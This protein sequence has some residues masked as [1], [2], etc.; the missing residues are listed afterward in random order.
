MENV[1]CP[2]C[3]APIKPTATFCLTCDTPV[4]DTERGLSVAAPVTVSV[5][6]PLVGLGIAT[7]CLVVLGALAWGTIA[8]FQHRHA[9]AM[10][11]ATGSVERGVA[12]LV[13]AEGGR[14]RACGGAERVLAGSPATTAHECHQIVDHDPG[15]RLDQLHVARP[16]L[17]ADSGTVSISATVS[18]GSG[19]HTIARVVDLVDQ[20]KHWHMSWDGRPVL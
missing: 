12:L 9:A 19:T 4:T 18:D 2:H 6:R 13:S 10:A 17:G 3:E 8:F 7:A 1:P 15:A 20:S 11:Q 14:A 16:R 5:G